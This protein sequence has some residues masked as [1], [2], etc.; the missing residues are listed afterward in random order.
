MTLQDLINSRQ[1][2]I[3]LYFANGCAKE[4][5]SEFMQGMK[6]RVEEDGLEEFETPLQYVNSQMREKDTL[7]YYRT[8][9]E[10]LASM[11]ASNHDYKTFN[12][13]TKRYN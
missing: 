11:M 8:G 9:K 6:N 13:L 7:K 1:E 12:H 5:L 3:D 4:R 2:I 10:S